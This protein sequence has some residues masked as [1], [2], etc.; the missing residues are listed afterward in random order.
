MRLNA[1]FGLMIALGQASVT[2]AG[3]A[4]VLIVQGASF[5]ERA[6]AE[7]KP[8]IDA[9]G[10]QVWLHGLPSALAVESARVVP[11]QG[12]W[13]VEIVLEEESVPVMADISTRMIGQPLAILADDTVLFSPVIQSKVGGKIGITIPDKEEA[14]RM[15]AL[16]QSPVPEDVADWF[17]ARES[18][19]FDVFLDDWP[20]S[21]FAEVARKRSAESEGN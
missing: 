3:I 13:R 19:E 15:V 6:D 20:D 16:I 14:E 8:F 2:H 1:L 18:G 10:G 21:R 4:G 7:V 5:E 9:P 11:F 17:E 12:W